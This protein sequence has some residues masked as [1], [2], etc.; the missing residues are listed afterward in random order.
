MEGSE[1]PWRGG[2]ATD[3]GW[4]EEENEGGKEGRKVAG[5]VKLII[6]H[7]GISRIEELENDA[8]LLA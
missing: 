5:C 2:Q 7:L 8:A 1:R 3:G 4:E 6:T